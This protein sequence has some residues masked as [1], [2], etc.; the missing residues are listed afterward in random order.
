MICRNKVLPEDIDDEY[1]PTMAS[2]SCPVTPYLVEG[3]ASPISG[4]TLGPPSPS[5]DKP[6]PSSSEAESAQDKCCIQTP[7]LPQYPYPGFRSS[8]SPPPVAKQP[9]SPERRPWWPSSGGNSSSH[10]RAEEPEHG[11]LADYLKQE[12]K[13]DPNHSPLQDV[14][15]DVREPPRHGEPMPQ[16]QRCNPRYPSSTG[17]LASSYSPYGYYLYPTDSFALTQYQS[18]VRRLTQRVKELEEQLK[19]EKE[20][21]RVARFEVRKK[22]LEFDGVLENSLGLGAE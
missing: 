13:R 18:E 20:S 4:Y 1:T 7:H 12:E 15:P 14:K 11:L 8:M 19:T 21:K 5:H 2:S 16:S 22:L 10:Q 6:V 17:Y 3:E 9:S